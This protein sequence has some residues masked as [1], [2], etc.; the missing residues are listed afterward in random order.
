MG[1]GQ[2]AHYTQ[3]DEKMTHTPVVEMYARA[4]CPYCARAEALLRQK[5][6]TPKIIR[7][8]LEPDQ[9][10][11]M[12]A[13]SGRTTVPQIFIDGAHVGGCDDLYQLDREG[14]LDAMLRAEH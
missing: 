14:K 9:R 8:D 12:V 4:G 11:E 3:K 5:N 7:I 6:V 2:F 1:K 13:R 10:D